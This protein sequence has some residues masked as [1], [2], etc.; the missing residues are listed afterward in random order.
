[1]AVGSFSAGLSGLNANAQALSVIRNNLA[2]TNT[3]AFKASRSTFAD[4]VS[5]NV[6]GS[7]ENP[8]QIGLGVG[9]SSI[10]PVFKQGAIESTS[11]AT[12]VAIQ[13]SGFFVLNG[14]D[15]PS[16]TRA[17]DFSFNSSGTLVTSDG[18]FVQGY[19]AIDPATGKVVT[20]SQPTNIVV[21]PGVLR[22]PTPTT[23]FAATTNL[24]AA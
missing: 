7:S 15:G 3:I 8:T 9:L 2:N 18:Q 17:G 1:M 14:S 16:Y 5:Q 11:S 23:Q 13:G 22:A 24:D 6:G 10:S 12:N 20:T 21:P 19:T 4:L